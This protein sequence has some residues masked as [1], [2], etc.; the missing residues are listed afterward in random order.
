MVLQGGT[1]PSPENAPAP[2]DGDPFDGMLDVRHDELCLVKVRYKDVGAAEED[3]AYQV[4][5]SLAAADVSD[6]AERA[7]CDLQ[8]A[9]AVA[10]LAERLKQSAFADPAHDEQIRSITTTCEGDDAHRI[11]FTRLAEQALNLLP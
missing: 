10:A 6:R 2:E 1:I 5:A 8:W 4:D 3:P 9:A 7:D 11:E